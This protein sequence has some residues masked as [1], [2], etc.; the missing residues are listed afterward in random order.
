M[1]FL[2]STSLVSGS[3]TVWMISFKSHAGR[4]YPYAHYRSPL[5]KLTWLTRN[6]SFQHQQ[7]PLAAV[8]RVL[9][10]VSI[11]RGAVCL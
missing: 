9:F 3:A 2:G 4:R 10:W 11:L 5:H 6:S 8:L 1:P 7:A